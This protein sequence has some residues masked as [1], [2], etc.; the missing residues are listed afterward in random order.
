MH[1]FSLL[2]VR[3]VAAGGIVSTAFCLLYKLFTLKLTRRQV[4][5]M[6]NHSD[7]P[8][9]RGLGIM[10]IRFVYM[11]VH[12]LP[13]ELV[14]ILLGI[15]SHLPISGTGWNPTSMMKRS[16]ILVHKS[17]YSSET[18]SLSSCLMMP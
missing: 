12:L 6:L 4:N 14:F 2:Q 11:Y 9:I 18:H 7:S 15:V 16:V 10:Y 3:G 13:N 5:T 1:V 8:Y 17:H